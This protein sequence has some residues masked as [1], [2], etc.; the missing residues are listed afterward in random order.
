MYPHFRFLML[1]SNRSNGFFVFSLTMWEF[2]LFQVTAVHALA[3]LIAT[4]N[5]APWQIL[6][7]TAGNLHEL[8][9][10]AEYCANI[11]LLNYKHS[12]IVL[13]SQQII[14]LHFFAIFLH[15]LLPGLQSIPPSINFMKSS[16]TFNLSSRLTVSALTFVS[17]SSNMEQVA[18]V[19]R[20]TIK[21]K[22]LKGQ[23]GP[24]VNNEKSSFPVIWSPLWVAKNYHF[25]S[26]GPPPWVT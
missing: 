21:S 11:Y 17:L 1:G 20:Q 8:S 7:N 2:G 12:A 4:L 23:L 22:H 10:I 5:W 9:A 14:V 6:K 26:F 3:Y 18:R 25:Q 13:Q 15:Q 16:K 24:P 19:K